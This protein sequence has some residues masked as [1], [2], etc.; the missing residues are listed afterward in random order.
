MWF[1]RERP[2]QR[3]KRRRVH[4]SPSSNARGAAGGAPSTALP[5]SEIILI[6]D[7]DEETTETTPRAPAVARSRTPA[8]APVA[9]AAAGA[10]R[11]DV[12]DVTDDDDDL[13]VVEIRAASAPAS[14]L[15][16]V[17]RER[18]QR[19]WE[20]AR[21]L[22][23]RRRQAEQMIDQIRQERAQRQGGAAARAGGPPSARDIASIIL[24]ELPITRPRAGGAGG[25]GG[26]RRSALRPG[27]PRM[28]FPVFL[29]LTGGL[30]LAR[31]ND[32][33]FLAHLGGIPT[34]PNYNNGATDE[35]IQ[36][37]PTHV[38]PD[39]KKRAREEEAEDENVKGD[40]PAA[41]E[42]SEECTVCME[43]YQPGERVSTLPCGH[44]YHTA[45]INKWL[46]ENKVRAEED[47]P[48]PDTAER[49]TRC[50]WSHPVVLA[51]GVL[52]VQAFDCM[53]Q[54]HRKAK[55]DRGA[56]AYHRGREGEKP[57]SVLPWQL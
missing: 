3:S 22:A 18:E 7:E 5:N 47:P 44:K 13:E 16:A 33:E 51:A 50:K 28:P 19:A 30:G 54:R 6:D 38:I 37:I 46:K 43:E 31:G 20:R 53:S 27:H 9:R 12:V 2:E 25:V 24:A 49:L 14:R 52:P 17:A 56:A 35:Q 23:Q 34:G 36:A 41:A 40:P 39:R 10:R 55:R 11:V 15:A 48:H 42:E 21:L 29:M 8:A 32:L 1:G 45:C 57:L 4:S 26:G